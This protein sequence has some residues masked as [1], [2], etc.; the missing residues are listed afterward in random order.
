MLNRTTG[1][2]DSVYCT[3]IYS[4]GRT[5]GVTASFDEHSTN[6]TCID[7]IDYNT[8]RATHYTHSA[9]LLTL[10]LDNRTEDVIDDDTEVDD[11]SLIDCTPAAGTEA[12]YGTYTDLDMGTFA[13]G[14]E[15]RKSEDT[16]GVAHGSTD[17]PAMALAA[18]PSASLP[19]D[20][21][22][23]LA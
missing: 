23:L 8:F 9:T 11:T 15:G 12:A 4:G 22:L 2:L 13:V 6:I 18:A 3:L 10:T 21:S 7:T 5:S 16:V 20:A 14:I 1:T 19:A 17:N